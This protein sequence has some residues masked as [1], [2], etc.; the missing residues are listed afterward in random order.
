MI[1][2]I[3]FAQI[4]RANNIIAHK[5][6][7]INDNRRN[8]HVL[9]ITA[10]QRRRRRL[11][12]PRRQQCQQ[13]P[14]MAPK[15]LQ[16]PPPNHPTNPLRDHLPP[17]PPNPSNFPPPVLHAK[18]T[19]RTATQTRNVHPRH[20]NPGGKATRSYRHPHGRDLRPPLLPHLLLPHDGP[21][22]KNE[23]T[24]RPAQDIGHIVDVSDIRHDILS[25]PRISSIGGGIPRHFEE[26]LRKLRHL[27]IFEFLDR[28]VGEGRSRGRGAD[29]E[30]ARG[31]FGQAV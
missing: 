28:R 11:V 1:K 17:L 6:Y 31:S 4:Q 2:V 7:Y 24:I 25:F 22:T 14:P 30:S 29:F 8:H 18:P 23:P 15:N 26:F 19:P 3:L 12:K 5:Q 16:S 13:Q 10:R 21:L 27:S 20:R 9:S